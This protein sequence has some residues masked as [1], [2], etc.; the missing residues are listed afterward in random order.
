MT[1]GYIA[2]RE[3]TAWMDLSGRGKISVRG[4]DRTRLLHAM[5]TN[6]IEQLQPGG[7]CYAFFLDAQGHIL[8]DV[9]VF[10][11][12]D[13]HLLDTEPETANKIRDHLD[14]YIIADDV[15]LE[16]LT[17][18]L[19]TL[20]LE[21][22]KAGEVLSSVGAP[23][24]EE[25][26]AHAAWGSNVIARVNPCGFFIFGASG[27]KDA[28]VSRLVAA[29]AIPATPQDA[30]VVRL[31]QGRPRYGTDFSEKNLPHE[32]QLLNAV[33]FN[34][35]CYLG[36]EIVERIR[37]RGHVNRLLVRLA[38]DGTRIPEA[39]VTS[40]AYSPAYGKV[41]AFAYVPSEQARPGTRVQVDGVEAQVL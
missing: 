18:A 12:E 19:A 39:G 15:T 33:H 24:P 41:L 20:S 37:S 28:L 5:T 16:D 3:S 7:G 35:G 32:T 4:Q 14:H 31:E 29:G 10:A 21:G 17:G 6:H 34:K 40:A 2:L 1:P 11:F 9:N 23:V 26:C 22:P 25:L 38:I 27:G 30:L 8:G 13:H 36:Q